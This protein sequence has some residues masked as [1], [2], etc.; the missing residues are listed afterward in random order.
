MMSM[1]LVTAQT[2]DYLGANIC[3][4]H[5]H[6]FMLFCWQNLGNFLGPLSPGFASVGPK[7][8]NLF[9]HCFVGVT[10]QNFLNY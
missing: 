4:L 6:N 1:L 3:S 7:N 5:S 9:A 8:T 2:S 10:M